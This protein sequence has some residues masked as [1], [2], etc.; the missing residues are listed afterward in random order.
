MKKIISII[1]I[2]KAVDNLIAFFVTYLEGIL[3]M[4]GNIIYKKEQEIIL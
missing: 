2:F 4:I 1:L 3:E